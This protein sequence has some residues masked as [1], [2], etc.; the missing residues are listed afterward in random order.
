VLDQWPADEEAVALAEAA[1]V[2][3]PE[4]EPDG[5]VEVF[6]DF[7]AFGDFEEVAEPVAVGPGA[8]GMV[9]GPHLVK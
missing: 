3:V 4:T 6:G 8:A 1:S 2:G 7:E 5:E 9:V